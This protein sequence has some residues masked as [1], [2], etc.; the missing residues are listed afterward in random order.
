M[1]KSLYNLPMTHEALTFLDIRRGVVGT[2]N[3]LIVGN[4]STVLKLDSLG[5]QGQ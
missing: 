3:L 5:G 1:T 2:L 4:V